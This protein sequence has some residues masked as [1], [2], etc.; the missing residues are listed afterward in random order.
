MTELLKSISYIKISFSNFACLPLS[1]FCCISFT[2]GDPH[3]F[4]K[5]RLLD[6]TT[7]LI[8]RSHH[9]LNTEGPSGALSPHP[10]QSSS[11]LI[12]HLT[13]SPIPIP[14]P[15]FR[16]HVRDR[17]PNPGSPLAHPSPPSGEMTLQKHQPLSGG[18]GGVMGSD[19]DLHSTASSISLPSVKKAPKKRRLSLASLFRRRGWEPKS[20]RQR[21]RELQQPGPSSLGGVDG[22]ASIESIH[23]EMCNDKNSAFF[24]VAGTGAASASAA[25]GAAT[26][27][28]ASGPS[29]STSSS[30]STSRGG[31]GLGAEA[32][33][34]PAV[35]SAPLKGELPWHHD[36][37]PPVLHRLPAPVPTH[38][39]LRVTGQ[40]QLPRVLRAFQPARHPHDIEW[41][42]T[43]GE[44]WG[45][46]AEEMACGWPWLPLV[47]CTRLWVSIQIDT[48]V[49]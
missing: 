49:L 46:H 34:V 16:G 11:S 13:P 24:Y 20:G 21:S 31:G 12:H 23:S 19:R 35:P 27:S 22:I 4:A 41:S 28:S 25:V 30:S 10:G 6:V 47:P 9:V 2:R 43:H 32:T 36:L 26:T 48:S 40:H 17:L 15:D 1:R 18:S 39:N 44:I 14:L 37:S 3:P 42:G 29:S 38:W 33:G 7:R 8:R 5:I 45:V